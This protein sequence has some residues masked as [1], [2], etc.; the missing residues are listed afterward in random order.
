MMFELRQACRGLIRRPA[1]AAAS[2]ATLALVIG[3][4]A[5]LFA[6]I[7]ATLF[8]PIPLESGARTVQIYLMPP[9][10]SDPKFRNPLHAIDL[11]RFRERARSVT[12]IAAFTTV[13]R[14]L[15]FD[16]GEPA[17]INTAAVSA[18]MFRLAIDKP[19]LGRAFTEEEETLRTPLLVISYGA[20]QRR[21]GGDR[22]VIGR[23]V[24]LDGDP[25]TIVGVMP[26]SF[27]P[28]FLEAE[29]WTP[30]GIT[31][32]AN[33]A[34]GRTYIQ[35]IAQLADGASFEQADSEVR[36]I[37]ADLA[38]E[39]PKTHQGWTGGILSFRD[40]Q[41]GAF[42]APLVVLFCAVVALLLIASANIASLTLAHVTARSGELALRRAIGAT[43][44]AVAR[45]VLLEISMINLVGAALAL[46]IGAWLLPTLLAI[47][48]ATTRVLGV[49]SIDWRVA[50]YAMGCALLSSL[51]A[52]LMPALNAADAAPALNASNTRS[53]GSRERQRWRNALLIAQTAICVGLLVS[54]GLLVRAME[55]TSRLS[56][57]YDPSNVLTAQLQL[58]P[59]RYASGPER[60][61]AMQRIF[62]RIAAIP[63]VTHSGATMNRFTPGFNYQTL[64][65][66]ENQPK[67]DGSAHTVQFRRVSD[68]YFSAMRIRVERGRVF[69]SQD[70]LSTP[71]VAV[72]SRSFA[73]RFWP[74]LDP[75]GRRM[76]RGTSSAMTVIGVVDDVSDVDL[77]LP[78]E[79][80]IYAAWSQT[81]NV[82]F[83]MGL[84][85][86]TAGDPEQ[87]TPAVRAAVASVDPLLALD[88]IQSLDT[89][90][91]DSLAPQKFRT[92]LMLGLALV[93][94]MLG[95]IGIAGV[96]ARS[97]A[98][99]MPEFG[100]RL[101]LGCDSGALWRRAV[102]D[103]VRVVG[104]GAIGGVVLALAASRVLAAMLP[105]TGGFDVTVVVGAVALLSATALVSAALPAARVLR[106]NPVAVLRQ[107]T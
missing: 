50:A 42:R 20:W 46:A 24:E 101:A 76:K 58:P 100:V 66:I 107:L 103:Q 5:A 29:A 96:T 2:I 8:R 102:T 104:V 72:V 35:T 6:A 88:R 17:V 62:D 45:L 73:E 91:A 14:V 68:T 90:L 82:A 1:Y 44:W 30:L 41:Y 37:V 22:S 93:G 21:L 39:L 38:R 36:A 59:S 31:K 27:P 95:A 99:R 60:V 57:G 69:T 81:A 80:T 33:P 97:V 70:S 26:R 86:R 10:L 64:V 25:Y 28:T 49:V 9:G 18:E 84:I 98:E 74:S 75:I 89:F 79:P 4:N 67:P 92:T 7:S 19:S 12:R 56:L 106:V 34:E 71:T 52:G 11:V 54:G 13:D 83:P 40:W 85:L 32:S 94:L 48:P 77:L 55:R 65:E 43:R 105:E 47:A 51:V 78:P 53:T 23:K 16:G 3:V 15:S 61:A 87:L 63:G